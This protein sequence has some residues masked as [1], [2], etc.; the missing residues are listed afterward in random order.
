MSIIICIVVFFLEMLTTKGTSDT[1]LLDAFK[2]AIALAVAA[3]PEGL[4]TVV[5]IILAIGVGNM[6]KRMQLLRNYLR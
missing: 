3:I 1:Y 6:A 2:T 5:T 4:A